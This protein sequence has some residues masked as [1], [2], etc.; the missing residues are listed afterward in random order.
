MLAKIMK[1]LSFI[2]NLL[3]MQTKVYLSLVWCMINNIAFL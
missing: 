2:L 3:K 1:K